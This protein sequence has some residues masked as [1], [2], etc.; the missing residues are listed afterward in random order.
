MHKL[1]LSLTFLSLLTLS[2]AQ[3]SLEAYSYYFKNSKCKHYEFGNSINHTN[4]GTYELIVSKSNQM[5]VTAGDDLVIDENGVYISKNKLLSI[6][7]E[8]V[9]ENSKY[10]VKNGYL[11]GILA[12]DSLPTFLQEESYY[13][14][15]PTKAFL[16]DKNSSQTL[17]QVGISSYIIFTKEDNGYY[18]IL[19]ITITNGIITLAEL[20][21]SY[22]ACNLIPHS[23]VSEND[24]KTFILNPSKQDWNNILL[25]AFDIYDRYLLKE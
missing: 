10:I 2:F 5:R 12:N 7:R 3:D 22:N 4:W 17:Y 18:S 9:R 6:S 23:I 11:H 8:E 13:F 19:N 20:D 1:I 21:L 24:I 14:L 16:Y 25:K 15:M